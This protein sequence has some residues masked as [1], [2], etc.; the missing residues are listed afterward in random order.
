MALQELVKVVDSF[1]FEI[2]DYVSTIERM[3]ESEEFEGRKVAALLASKVYL[4][5][6]D[7]GMSVKFALGAGDLF[8]NDTDTEYKD[9]IIGN[10]C[11]D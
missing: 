2:S 10:M 8:L 9:F 11:R 7:Y 6:E 3:Y 1:W 5:L 4:R